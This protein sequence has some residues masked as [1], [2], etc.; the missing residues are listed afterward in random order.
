MS[1][2][3]STPFE[4]ALVDAPGKLVALG[5]EMRAADLEKKLDWM[6]SANFTRF[7]FTLNT[8]ERSPSLCC[9]CAGA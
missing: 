4:Q 5:E 3:D 8:D 7:S 9:L 2:R 6:H 1:T